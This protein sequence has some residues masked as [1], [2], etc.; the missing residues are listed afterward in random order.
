MNELGGA[1]MLEELY[2]V[3]FLG[4]HWELRNKKPSCVGVRAGIHH[5]RCGS[6]IWTSLLLLKE[7]IHM[8]RS[9]QA[10]VGVLSSRLQI[11]PKRALPW[12]ICEK[13]ES[14]KGG[15]MNGQG[16]SGSGETGGNKWLGKKQ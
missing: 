6:V 9:G 2:P 5:G 14:N 13:L 4:S 16:K 1:A 3:I 8:E 12:G 10:W 11:P 15:K 7:C